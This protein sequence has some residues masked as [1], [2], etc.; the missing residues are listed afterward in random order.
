MDEI[1]CVKCRLMIYRLRQSLRVIGYCL[2][3]A[4]IALAVLLQACRLLTPHI[5]DFSRDIEGF[6]GR[7]INA[8]VHL[9]QL[10]A[11]W[12]GLRPK[13]SVEQ[14]AI[15][16]AQQQPVAHIRRGVLELDILSSVW[17]WTPVW[18]QVALQGVDLVVKQDAAGGW[19][20]GGVSPARQDKLANTWR[21]RHPGALFLMAKTVDIQSANVTLVLNN[22]RQ[23]ATTSPQISI[24]N[25]GHFHRLKAQ[26]SV[27]GQPSV[28]EFVMEGI[29]DP[30][31][32]EH[33]FA[34][35]HLRLNDFPLERIA[36]F[37]T[38][39][40][41]VS[42]PV[43]TLPSGARV[44]MALWFDFA[45]PS[46]FLLDGHMAVASDG[47]VA[48]PW[49]ANI[50]GD[51]AI[52]SGLSLGLRDIEGDQVLDLGALAVHLHN[53]Q[54]SLG[55]ERFDLASLALLKNSPLIASPIVQQALAGLSPQGVLKQVF[56]EADLLNGQ[57]TRIRA[58]VAGGAIRPWR[59]VPGFKQVN[60][61]LES[62]LQQGFFLLDTEDFE[63]FPKKVY[64]QPLALDLAR[65]HISWQLSAEG[66]QLRG[67][68]LSSSSDYGDANGHFL[69]NF[70][71]QN[72]RT[73]SELLLQ[74]GL[75]NSKARYH[76]QLIPKVLPD[77]FSQWLNQSVK[78]GDIQRAG[79][80][81]R[82]GFNKASAQV[83]QV[84]VDLQGGR[85]VLK[86]GWPELGELQGQITVDNDRATGLLHHGRIYG[87]SAF[88]GH[89]HWS[90]SSGVVA[91]YASSQGVAVKD[92]LR[93]IREARF[94]ASLAEFADQVTAG[95]QFDIDL[96]LDIPLEEGS[97]GRQDIAIH[98]RQGQLRLTDIDLPFKH[99][100]GELYY[101]TQKG[102]TSKQL[103]AS[104]FDRP[105]DLALGE[106]DWDSASVLMLK[107]R[108]RSSAK[109][110]AD[111]LQ[112]PA[113]A[114]LSGEFSYS[115]DLQIPL[116][117]DIELDSRLLVTTDLVGVAAELPPPFYKSADSALPLSFAVYFEDDFLDYK[118]ELASLFSSHY[119]R[120]DDQTFL[121]SMAIS[122]TEVPAL[123]AL[124]RSGLKV[125]AQFDHLQG[126]PWLAFLK[127][128]RQSGQGTEPDLDLF[129][130]LKQLSVQDY[131]FN[132]LLISGQRETQGWSLV[133]DGDE[134][135]GGIYFDGSQRPLDVDIDHFKLP[136]RPPRSRPVAAIGEGDDI[137]DSLALFNPTLFPAA[138]IAINRL[139]Y[140]D[141]PLG[142]WSFQ[143]RPDSHGLDIRQ[144]YGTVAGLSLAGTEAEQGAYLRWQKASGLRPTS[145]HFT[146]VLS[147]ASTHQFLSQWQLPS[148][149]DSKAMRIKGDFFWPGSP[150]AF[151]V[152]KA[153]GRLSG[154]YKDGVFLQENAGGTTGLLKVLGVLN[155]DSWARRIRLDFSDVYQKG[156]SFNVLKGDIIFDQGMILF[157][158]PIVAKG[159]SSHMALV[160]H[161]DYGQ[162]TIDGHLT[163][164][165]PIGGNLTLVTAL[166]GGLP[167]AAG[168]YI[169]SKLF[170]DQVDK[171]SSINYAIS[172]HWND[173]L[174][175]VKQAE[176]EAFL[177]EGESLD[178][179]WPDH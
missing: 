25:D 73:N 97:D 24:Q 114:R 23:L 59:G 75:V 121:A 48:A 87:R 142:S 169:V 83:T 91:A 141:K 85:L 8:Q 170:D 9:G 165:L 99:I 70:P 95:G 166:A 108:G 90:Q 34:K 66:A 119:R 132:N 14:L 15:V 140:G 55:V 154:E 51:Y 80:L 61:Y 106:G 60:G 129:L 122:D 150:L 145:T 120:L 96:A 137:E 143:L 68:N 136:A 46:R 12:H 139:F 127:S 151:R 93:F 67:Q 103:S 178:L 105:V 71:R 37:L 69:I 11:S 72:W 58:N 35:A 86:P 89:F 33:F 5:N 157:D 101:S 159:P 74:V 134:I 28:F 81:Y 6:I 82:G 26:A 171:V 161:I 113:L 54:L 130:S 62:N 138:N 164:T 128:V 110:V 57:Q 176:E 153:K 125:L 13:V 147:G 3:T 63:V 1:E 135:L 77:R 94:N 47:A 112:R 158:Q 133:V 49:R 38:P 126:E 27:S 16:S 65:G 30:S 111:W 123:P 32:P 173:P 42:P 20:I 179:Q 144:I 116:A 146:G 88:R 79:L 50:A 44:D 84:F 10:Q 2:A 172:G 36:R 168:I 29:G 104:L 76:R 177:T 78:G 64:D 118:L 156:I 52:N 109:A 21:Y 152:E 40:S 18:R 7:Q 131:H 102:V 149:V 98:L 175:E 167:A 115:A 31:E 43:S 45:G 162:Q 117:D 19:S 148:I 174:V 160:G 163:V 39:P 41:V 17:H 100:N 4:I 92:G 107:A 22:Q 56:I 155:F 53:G 124:P